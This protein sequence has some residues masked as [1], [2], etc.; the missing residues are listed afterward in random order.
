[1]WRF[2]AL[3]VAVLVAGAGC[4]DNNPEGAEST[5]PADPTESTAPTDAALAAGEAFRVVPGGHDDC[6]ATVLTSGWPTTTAFNSEIAAQCIV[7]AAVSGDPA[8]YAVWGRD[9]RG[10]IVG[11]IIRV[12]GPDMIVFIDFAVDPEGRTDSSDAPC[13]ELA[14]SPFAPPVCAAQ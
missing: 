12:D 4:S 5:S 8:Q 7:A 1:M 14:S 3:V 9:G 10:G 11:T 2:G 13:R 6:G